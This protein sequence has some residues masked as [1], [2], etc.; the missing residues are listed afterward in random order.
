[1]MARFVIQNRIDKTD[2]IIKFNEAGYT[3][4]SKESTPTNPVFI[5]AEA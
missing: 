1:M 4:H 2:D 3:Y 5:R